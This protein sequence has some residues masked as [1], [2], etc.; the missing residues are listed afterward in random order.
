LPPVTAIRLPAP[1]DP[2]DSVLIRAPER[3]EPGYWAGCPSVLPDEDVTWLTY[4]ERRP[5]GAASERG[6]RC[7][8]AVSHDGLRFEDVWEVHK[9]A[10]ESPSMERFDLTRISDG[11][12][13]F[14]SSVDPADGRWRIDAV[15][16]TR[17]DA[18]DVTTRRPILTADST[19][20][21]GVKDPVVVDIGGIVHLFASFAAPRAGLDPSAHATADVYNTGATTHPTGLAIH[22]GAGF[23]WRGE[24]LGVGAPGSWDGYQARLG[25][26]VGAGDA[27]F[28]FY[29]GSAGHHENYEERLGIA[30]SPDGRSWERASVDGP[31]LLGPGRTGSVRYVDIVVRADAWW[32]YHEVTRPDGA[33]ELRVARVPAPAITD[34]GA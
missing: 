19:A 4:R 10:L 15:T 7:A 6:W 23:R 11:Y 12:E 24:A 16:A 32:I 1:F 31:W 14:L 21:E 26:I 20:T 28:G 17:P 18:F 9:D 29:D 3:A 27:F 33:H 30:T 2:A 5:R 22:D 25:S 13:L 34:A 8:V